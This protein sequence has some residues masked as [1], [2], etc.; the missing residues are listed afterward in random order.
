MSASSKFRFRL[1]SW[2]TYFFIG[3]PLL[4]FALAPFPFGLGM[5]YPIRDHLRGHP[6]G[7]HGTRLQKFVGLWVRDQAVEFDFVGQ[8]FFLLADGRFAG[9]PGMTARRWHFDNNCLFIDSVSRCGNCYRGNV[10]TEYSANFLGVDQLFVM[11]KDK[12][13]KNGIGGMYRRVEVTNAYRSQLNRL[14][15]SVDNDENFKAR[16][17]LAAVE[18]FEAMSK[19]R[20]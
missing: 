3:V 5:V 16:V 8:A 10:T 1:R 20:Y 4:W 18:Q 13:A 2:R 17:T 15:R 9:I 7:P 14:R 11:N 19:L 12:S 6:E